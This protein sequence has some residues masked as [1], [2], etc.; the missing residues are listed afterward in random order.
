MRYC[1]V[2][3][4]R[5]RV[6]IYQNVKGLPASAAKAGIFV[7][8]ATELRALTHFIDC[9]SAFVDQFINSGIHIFV[10]ARATRCPGSIVLMVASAIKPCGSLE[11]NDMRYQ[12]SLPFFQFGETVCDMLADAG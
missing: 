1:E 2:K 6:G 4:A 8:G 10:F 11:Q 3:R 12:V 7:G 9:R 5:R